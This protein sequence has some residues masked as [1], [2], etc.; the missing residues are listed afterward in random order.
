M[1]H[2]RKLHMSL[3]RSPKSILLTNTYDIQLK[4]IHVLSKNN[5]I[6]KI[7]GLYYLENGLQQSY[8][9]CSTVYVNSPTNLYPQKCMQSIVRCHPNTN[10][11]RKLAFKHSYCSKIPNY[12]STLIWSRQ[13]AHTY[14]T[15]SEIILFLKGIPALNCQFIYQATDSLTFL[16]LWCLYYTFHCKKKSQRPK[17]SS[18]E[19]LYIR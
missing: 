10:Q 14:I 16:M 13:E 11:S 7:R 9:S 5:A 2:L 19:H 12:G 1:S 17:I 18:E 8:G 3:I 15:K 6:A 4:P